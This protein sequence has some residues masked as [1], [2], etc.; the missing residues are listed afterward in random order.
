MKT[1]LIRYQTHPDRT[2]ENERLIKAVFAELEATAP[3]GV[4]YAALALG[5]GSFV[6]F[7][8]VDTKD[9]SNPLSKIAAFAAFQRGIQERCLE[10]PKSQPATIVGNYRMFPRE[11]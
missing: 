1:T 9:G 4:R 11:R 8:E 3:E 6:H 2:E 5:D 7:V 10:Q